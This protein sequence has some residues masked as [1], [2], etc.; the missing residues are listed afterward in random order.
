MSSWRIRLDQARQWPRIASPMWVD[1]NG[2]LGASV[3]RPIAFA[4]AGIFSEEFL[5]VDVDLRKNTCLTK[6]VGLRRPC[7]LMSETEKRL[8]PTRFPQ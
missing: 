3:L 8:S 4:N 7:P 1:F 2:C 5:V 6:Y